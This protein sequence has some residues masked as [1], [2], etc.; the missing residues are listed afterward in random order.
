MCQVDKK[1]KEATI[2]QVKTLKKRL[3]VHPSTMFRIN[4]NLIQ[5][6][7]MIKF[8]VVAAAVVPSTNCINCTIF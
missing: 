6:P 8:S 3:S 2:I 5:S 1:K 4:K 7:K